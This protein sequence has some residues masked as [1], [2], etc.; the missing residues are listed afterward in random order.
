METLKK[1]VKICLLKKIKES[2]KLGPQKSKAHLK[3]LITLT[4][5]NQ[6]TSS[7]NNTIH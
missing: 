5:S 2:E 3:I 4:T 7:P 6:M 1:T